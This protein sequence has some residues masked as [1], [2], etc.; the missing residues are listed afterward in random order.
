M[1]LLPKDYKDFKQKEYWDSFFKKR[2]KKAFE[3]YGEYGELCGVLHQYTKAQDTI[4]QIGCGNSTLASDLYDV[5][6]RSIRSIDISDLVISMMSEQNKQRKELIFEKMD[7]TCM[8]YKEASF[9]VVLDKGTLDALFTDTTPEVVTRVEAMFGEIARVLKLGG[10]YVCVSLLQ[11][12]I[13]SHLVPWFSC[14][15]W[16]VRILRCQEAEDSKAPQDRG[17][18]VFVVVVTKFR[19][20]EGAKPILELGLRS[21]G[22]L[23]RLEAPE[24]LVASVR[25]V[26]QFA[27]LRAN[28][29]GGGDSTQEEVSLDLRPPGSDIPRYSLFLADRSPSAE[30]LLKSSRPF[31]A[32][33]VPEG[34]EVE[35]LFASAEGRSQLCDSAGPCARLV[36]VH[37]GRS[38]TF[39]SLEQ[40]QEELGGYVLELSPSSLPLSYQVP[41]LSAGAEAVGKREERCRGHSVLS[42]DYV[43]EDVTAGNTSLRRLI[44][45]SR[46]HLTQSEAILKEVRTKNKK[47]KLVVDT[48]CL[49]STYH[50]VMVGALGLYLSAPVR[51]LVVGLG[52][53]SLPNYIHATF[54]LSNVHVVELDPAIVRVASDQFAFKAGDRLTVSAAD[55][56]NF[57]Q[58]TNEQF[59]LVMLDVDSKDISSGMSCPP[60]AF[61]EP[62]FLSAV[63]RVLGQGGML[64]LNLVCRDSV[65][66][67]R[68][69][70]G[71]AEVW[72]GIVSYKLEEEVNE[73]VFCSN[74]QKLKTGEVKQTITNAFKLVNDHVRKATKEKDELIDLEDS[75]K[76]LKV[77][78]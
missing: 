28:L 9:S 74:A 3:W 56:I 55:G 61:L 4:L 41:F 39:A 27:A 51:V 47:T 50:G 75:L 30:K 38:N 17:L 19:Q 54:P 72:D 14:R 64:V 68:V 42:G 73:I 20:I 33:V 78:H 43:V 52:G 63:A 7:A 69:M 77:T 35:W 48:G 22:Q 44:F 36:V 18:P 26:Q 23:T 37:L 12:H 40:V 46:P 10:R 11:E 32:F 31:A 49:A 59:A 71:L 8:R 53:G 76:L 2:G 16:P 15:G 57:I 60:P 25:G 65:L 70:A 1:D 67:S 66:R 29:A 62:G 45:L 13:L 5:G 24:Q 21:T 58:E 6:Y 34:R